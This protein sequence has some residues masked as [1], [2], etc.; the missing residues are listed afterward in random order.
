MSAYKDQEKKV[1]DPSYCQP[2]GPAVV[3]LACVKETQL[4]TYTKVKTLSFVKD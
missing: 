1:T 2:L 3:T 4:Q